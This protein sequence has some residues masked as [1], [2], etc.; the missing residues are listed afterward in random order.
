MVTDEQYLVIAEGCEDMELSAIWD[1]FAMP[2]GTKFLPH[3]YESFESRRE[4]FLW[5]VKR[6]LEEGRIKLVNM[7]SHV[8]V[9]GT[10][11][12]QVQ[13]LRE[14]FPKNEAEIDNGLWFY[15]EECPG[16]SAWQ[17]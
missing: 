11:E 6:L 17:H 13:R 1:Y 3:P 2:L 4:A 14:A 16:G 5:V 12:E 10:V 8:P 7:R 15:S 9:E